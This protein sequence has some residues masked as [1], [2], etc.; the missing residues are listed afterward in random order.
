MVHVN[1]TK[2]TETEAMQMLQ[3]R[4]DWGLINITSIINQINQ[5]RKNVMTVAGQEGRE[6]WLHGAIFGAIRRWFAY[7][8][9][10]PGTEWDDAGV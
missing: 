8:G 6:L 10:N 9:W 2:I 4:F 3:R 1:G 5:D 7:S